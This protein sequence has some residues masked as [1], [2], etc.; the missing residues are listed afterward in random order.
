MPAANTLYGWKLTE[1]ACSLR[2]WLQSRLL[3]EMLAKNLSNKKVEAMDTNRSLC[4]APSTGIEPAHPA[5]EAGALS[6]ELRGRIQD[7]T[8]CTSGS[9][10]E[11]RVQAL[12]E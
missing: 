11:V 10:I 2:S 1:I 5:P 4:L 8:N 3:P 7:Y 9:Q 12:W 6:S